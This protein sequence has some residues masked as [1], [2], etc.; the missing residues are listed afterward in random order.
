MYPQIYNNAGW[1]NLNHDIKMK[2]FGTI[3]TTTNANIANQIEIQAAQI[4]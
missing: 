1:N 3:I 2:I 4:L